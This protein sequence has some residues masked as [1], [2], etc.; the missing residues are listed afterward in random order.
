VNKLVRHCQW[1]E[2]DEELRGFLSHRIGDTTRVSWLLTAKMAVDV[3][4]I[5]AP[6]IEEAPGDV[7]GVVQEASLKR[8]AKAT[9]EEFGGGECGYRL[10]VICYLLLGWI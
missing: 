9:G 6:E 4:E 2:K 3:G 7:E 8:N 10:D 5:V 1:R